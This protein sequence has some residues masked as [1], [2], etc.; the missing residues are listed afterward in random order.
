MFHLDD[1]T[2]RPH[3]TSPHGPKDRDAVAAT[4]KE[5][6]KR[7]T[8]PACPDSKRTTPA[9]VIIALAELELYTR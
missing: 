1:L 3:D 2:A 5:R 6:R 9:T 4:A 8:I 7:D